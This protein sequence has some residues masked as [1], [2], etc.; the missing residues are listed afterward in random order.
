MNAK[1]PRKRFRSLLGLHARTT[2]VQ[3]I[4]SRD[5]DCVARSI[6]IAIGL[7]YQQVYDLVNSAAAYERTGTRKRGISNATTGVYKTSIKRVMESLGWV[8]N[9]TMHIGSGCTV[10]FRAKEL[11]PGGLG[12]TVSKHLTAGIDR[13]IYETHDPSR[14]GKRCVYGYWRPGGGKAK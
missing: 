4:D 7:P 11:P 6:A 5:G 13:G 3:V 8:W 12:V 1:T 9:P 2:S 14:R 10:H